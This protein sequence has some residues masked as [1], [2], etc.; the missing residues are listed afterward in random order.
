RTQ[1]PSIDAVLELI[2]RDAVLE[3]LDRALATLAAQSR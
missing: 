2:G 1:T 3:R